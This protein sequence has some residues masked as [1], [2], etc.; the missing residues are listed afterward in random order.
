VTLPNGD[1]RELD[2]AKGYI[3]TSGY[4]KTGVWITGSFPFRDTGTYKLEFVDSKGFAYVNIP[5]FQ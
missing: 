3:D 4:L 5:L 1:V 2:F